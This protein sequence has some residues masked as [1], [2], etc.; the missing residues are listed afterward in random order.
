MIKKSLMKFARKYLIVWINANMR[1]FPAPRSTVKNHLD[2]HA[3]A[4]VLAGARTLLARIIV[5]VQRL[6]VPLVRSK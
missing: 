2:I 1:W 4:V 6:M 5:L 3:S